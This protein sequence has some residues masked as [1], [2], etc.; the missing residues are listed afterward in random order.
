MMKALLIVDLQNDFCPGGA[1]PAP[2]GD[3]VVPVI[4]SIMHYFPLV[5]ASKDWHPDTTAHFG[6]WPKH[7][8]QN[9]WG[10]ELHPGL[11][12]DIIHQVALKGTGDRD[13]GYSAFEASNINLEQYLKERS[14]DSLYITG[15]AIEY[16][17]KKSARDA[18]KKGFHTFVVRDAVA[19]IELH[20]GDVERALWEMV[21]A[22]VML[23]TSADI[24]QG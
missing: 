12:Q 20:R 16:C 3:K 24:S 5:V 1:L 2:E 4:N 23:V 14:V 10:A 13:E 17:V 8:V 19:G 7:C 9:S 6:A 21:H 15:I 11:R 22:G 18:V